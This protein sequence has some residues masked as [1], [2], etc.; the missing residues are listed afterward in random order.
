MEEQSQEG[1][2]RA[3][4][5]VKESIGSS[6]RASNGAAD[7]NGVLE[8][9]VIEATDLIERPRERKQR[10]FFAGMAES[11]GVMSRAEY[12]WPYVTIRAGRDAPRRTMPGIMSMQAEEDRRGSHNNAG[13]S[14]GMVAWHEDFVF[15][16][17]SSR[18]EVVVTCYMH[19]RSAGPDGRSAQCS[20]VGDVHIPVNRLPEGHAIEQWYQLLPQQETPREDELG[21]SRPRP[22]R[23]G[24]VSKAAIKLRLYYQVRDPAFAPRGEGA[25][26]FVGP[27]TMGRTQRIGAEGVSATYP[28]P[29]S[30]TGASGLDTPRSAQESQSQDEQQRQVMLS[31]AGGGLLSSA[32]GTEGGTGDPVE[33]ASP[34]RL[35]TPSSMAELAQEELPTGLVDYFCIMGPRLDEATGL[36]SLHNGAIL[37]RHPVEDKAGQPLPD[38]P[39]FFCFPAGMALAYGPSP[40]KPAPLAYTFVIKHSGVSSYG[41][42]LH[43][44]RRWEQ[45]SKN[46]LSPS[47][48]L[49]GVTG[50]TSQEHDRPSGQ[51]DPKQQGT[52]VWAP[53]CFCLL[54]R[55]PVVQPLLNWLVHAYDHMDRLLPPTYDALLGDP[56]DPASVPG[57]HLTDLLRTHIVQLTLE[58][59]L[60]IPVALG[61]Q[62]DFLGRP[63]TCRL[64]GPG[65]LPSLCYPLSPFLRTF[66]ARNVLALVAAALTE[67]KVLLHSHDLSVLPVMA[68][69]LL[70][71]IYPLQWQHPYLVPLPRELLVVVETPTN[72]ILG[73]H[74][75]WLADVPRDSLKD[76]VC[77]DCD[78]GAVRLPPRP[79]N[80]PSFPPSVLY[81]L[82]RRLRGTVY[83]MLTRLDSASSRV[84]LDD[85]PIISTSAPSEISPASEEELRRL[86]LRCLAYLLSGYHDCVF[87]I[88]PNSPIFNRARFLAEYAPAEDHAFLSRLLDTQ[89]FQAFLEN[90]D[91]PS[92]NLFRRTLFQAFSRATSRPPSPL[93]GETTSSPA[94]STSFPSLKKC[95]ADFR[96]LME[97]E[98]SGNEW[99]ETPGA[100]HR[101]THGEA[102]EQR[103]SAGRGGEEC[104][105]KLM[106]KIPPP[107]LYGETEEDESESDG[108]VDEDCDPATTRGEEAVPGGRREFRF[109]GDQDQKAE[110]WEGVSEERDVSGRQRTSVRFNLGE[111]ENPG[112]SKGDRGDSEVM[113]SDRMANTITAS[114]G[115]STVVSAESNRHKEKRA[116]AKKARRPLNLPGLAVG[117]PPTR[118]SLEGTFGEADLDALMRKT[119]NL[120]GATYGRN[121][122]A[123]SH[124]GGYTCGDEGDSMD[125]SVVPARTVDLDSGYQGGAA[126]AK[127]PTNAATGVAWRKARRWSVEAAAG[128]MDVTVRDVARAF[129]LNF[130]LQ[131]VMTRGHTIFGF[132]DDVPPSWGREQGSKGG[133]GC[134][135]GR[136]T[137]G[138][139]LGKEDDGLEKDGAGAQTGVL[140]GDMAKLNRCLAEAFSTEKPSKELFREVEIA[141]RARGV[142]TRFLA[143]LSQPRSK[144]MIQRHQFLIGGGTSGHFR[145]HSTGFEA[146]MQ[147]A[148]AVCDACVVDRDFPTAHALLQLM[149]KYYRV[150]EGGGGGNHAWAAATLR[151][152][153]GGAGAQQQHKEFLSSRL[154]HHQI[155]QCVEL[156][157][158]V[159]EEQLGAGKGPTATR[160]DSTNV[161]SVNGFKLA[162]APGAKTTNRDLPSVAEADDPSSVGTVDVKAGGKGKGS[163]LGQGE[164]AAEETPGSEMD[165]AEVDPRKFILRV[166][167]ILAEMHGVGM[168]DHRALAFVGRICEVHEAGMESKQA[169]VRL[170]QKIWGISPAPTPQQMFISQEP[171]NRGES[172]GSDA[173]R[174]AASSSSSSTSPAWTS[175]EGIAPMVPP[176]RVSFQGVGSEIG[177][178]SSDSIGDSV[179][180]NST[181]LNDLRGPSPSP[182]FSST[183]SSSSSGARLHRSTSPISHLMGGMGLGLGMGSAAPPEA[184]MHRGPVLSVDVDAAGSVGVSGGADKLLIVYSLQQRSRITSFSGHT[185]PVTCVKI[186]RDHAN[187]PLVASASMDSTLRIWKLGGGG[188]GDPGA[189]TGARLLSS[190][191]TAKD[192]RH[193]LT[194]HAKGIVCLDK[195]EDLQLLATGAMDRAVKLWNV[196]Q[197]RNTAT[198]I[199]HTRTVNSLRFMDQSQGYRILSAGQ[200]RTMILWDSG[201]GSCIRVFKGH[202]SWIR[203]V[204]A[205]G[206]DLAVTASNDRTLRVWDLR[207][208]NCVQKL[209]EHKGAV[210]CMQV[211]KEQDAPVVYSGSTDS[212]VKIWDLRGGGG[213]CTATLE[214]HAEAVTGLALESPMAAGIGKS[215]NGGGSKL[216]HQKLVSVGEDKRVVEW[217]TR[218][219]ALLQSRMGHSDGISCV[220]VSKYGVIVTGSWD[221]SVRLWEGIQISV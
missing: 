130:D 164:A 182:S 149:G 77:V 203:Q 129:G 208:H 220:Q 5:G 212:T 39:Q 13:L 190:F 163:A 24:V 69:S 122:P 49:L 128:M 95:P 83:P 88:D 198:L 28:S 110:G 48:G 131:R 155:Y 197:G 216:V 86:F 71:L 36:P 176:R 179:R 40:P 34:R 181:L 4:P 221:A 29:S 19:R 204:E 102:W 59:P 117:S 106:L 113:S 175:P 192:V 35:P 196:S 67:S 209:A 15:G 60:P 94:A 187:D 186:F 213:R 45:L 18:E 90:Q 54:T 26:A 147:L 76:V 124:T 74:T 104:E 2:H 171:V 207:V 108:S 114:E 12:G 80:P 72:Y 93:P 138:S 58:V 154:R 219:G 215:K 153:E 121:V 66:S 79:F 116:K 141:F 84:S 139:W 151:Q 185:G 100:G 167:S 119:M 55:V 160:R 214:G 105:V 56:L 195:C 25:V 61:V 156:W 8:V 140:S 46:V 183:V 53:V 1:D 152:G 184:S 170:V 143:I 73:V 91:G 144:R 43:F 7:A 30:T 92:I 51:E 57:A 14:S 210:T 174:P 120:T 85:L 9:R 16:P 63:I 146:L 173:P 177:R 133:E 217:D 17:V 157:M 118:S 38:S 65:A 168:P 134:R 6:L 64:A 211:S 99:L 70:S 31:S 96:I 103:P 10:S 142:R 87:Y 112:E 218:T 169:L 115:L 111:L 37:L 132:F 125:S 150:L 136:A 3:G 199:G 68:E 145:V 166:K 172:V 107:P 78:S 27:E 44:H 200:D 206:R 75:E 52:T 191:T 42:C 205:W 109:D 178:R 148:S 123:A 23:K 137:E 47:V 162:K 50:D 194:G 127:G 158:H 33:G 101:E 188:G 126:E 201:R 161:N 20:V 32:P 21:R 189:F 11:S 202:E 82:L 135:E 41:V 159:L 89:S 62:F 81:P 97:E 165:D 98:E 193:I 22:S 180:K